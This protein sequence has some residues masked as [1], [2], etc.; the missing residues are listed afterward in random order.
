MPSRLRSLLLL[1]TVAFITGAS[2]SPAAAFDDPQSSAPLRVLFIGNSQCYYNDLPRVLETIAD[3]APKDRPRIKTDRSLTGGATLEY[4][5]NQGDGKDTPRG[6]IAGEK[7]DYVVVQEFLGYAAPEKF[8]EFSDKFRALIEQ[9]GSKMVLLST[10]HVLDKIPDGFKEVHAQNSARAKDLKVIL[11]PGG[12]AWLA[13]WGDQPTAEQRLDLFN[14]DKGHPGPKGTYLYACTLYA[15]L[16]GQSPVGLAAA[17]VYPTHGSRED[18][19]S[20][21]QA[22]QFQEAAWKVYQELNGKDA[23]KEPSE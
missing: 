9:Q 7:W 15:T 18:K 5:W 12:N 2:L 22:K 6:K 1:A 23:A 3:A 19:I 11:V 14:P 10:A 16:T 4:H 13:Y 21:E 20:P 8:V 17:P